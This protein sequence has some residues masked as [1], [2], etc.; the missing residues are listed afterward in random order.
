MGTRDYRQLTDGRTERV[1]HCLLIADTESENSV[2]FWQA[3]FCSGCICHTTTQRSHQL[4][5]AIVHLSNRGRWQSLLT[6]TLCTL[7]VTVY[8]TFMSSRK[9]SSHASSWTSRPHDHNIQAF[10]QLH[11]CIGL[12]ACRSNYSHHDVYGT[13][14]PVFFISSLWRSDAPVISAILRSWLNIPPHH[15]HVLY[16]ISWWVSCWKFVN[17]VHDDTE[18]WCMCRPVQYFLLFVVNK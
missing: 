4:G 13:H 12:S 16:L 1:K 6:Q 3:F 10:V 7:W 17:G 8:G 11:W 5:S 2:I 14:W 18:R 15:V 9:R